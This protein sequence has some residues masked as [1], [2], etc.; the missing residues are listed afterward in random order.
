MAELERLIPVNEMLIDDMVAYSYA[1]REREANGICLAFGLVMALYHGKADYEFDMLK[2]Q[3]SK[4]KKFIEK[5][6]LVYKL[7]MKELCVDI[8]KDMDGIFEY[9]YVQMKHLSTQ[10]MIGAAFWNEH[11]EFCTFHVVYEEEEKKD[12]EKEVLDFVNEIYRMLTSEKDTILE[13]LSI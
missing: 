10:R 7:I 13:M 8:Q 2:I 12:H 9:V 4:K 6:P 1:F 11:P 3:P 5:E